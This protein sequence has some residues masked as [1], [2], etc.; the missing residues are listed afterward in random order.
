MFPFV[1]RIAALLGRFWT[2][3]PP[4]L[5]ENPATDPFPGVREPRRQGPAGRGAAIALAEPGPDND[6][7]AVATDSTRGA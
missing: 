1:R 5:P 3:S 2:G 4:D 7:R 6:V